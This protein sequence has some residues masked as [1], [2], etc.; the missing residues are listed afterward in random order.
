M[1]SN[2]MVSWFANPARCAKCVLSCAASSHPT[3]SAGSV[4]NSLILQ[5]PGLKACYGLRWGFDSFQIREFH[6]DDLDILMRHQVHKHTT[7]VFQGE[8][9][10]HFSDVYL[11]PI[12]LDPHSQTSIYGLT[13]VGSRAEVEAQLAAFDASPAVC[14]AQFE[15]ARASIAAPSFGAEGEKY[16]FS[17]A[18]MRATLLC[19][20]VYPAYARRSHIRHSTPGRW[21]DSLYTWDSGFI[22]LGLLELDAQRAVDCLNA[23]MTEPGD[24]HA[25]YAH[26]GSP[27]PVQHYLFLELWNRTQSR[28]QLEHFY[29]RLKGFYEFLAGRDVRSRTRKFASISCKPGTIF[30]IRAAGTITRRKSTFTTRSWKNR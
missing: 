27:V 18:R 26:H 10:G 1:K 13:C 25:A 12:P 14:E 28:E 15:S 8:G 11:H 5:Y 2:W 17:Q 22:G 9:E 4:P 21:W 23:Y 29:P 30:T 24:P 19:N 20:V 16:E 3:L 6:C 7:K